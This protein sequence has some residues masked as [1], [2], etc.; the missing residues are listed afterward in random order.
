MTTNEK[1]LSMVSSGV[2]VDLGQ[3]PMTYAT[4]VA[5]ANTDF[6][7]RGLRGNVPAL[8]AC[9]LSG[10]ELGLG[11]MESL[12]KIDVIDGRPATSAELLVAMVYKAGHQIFPVTITGTGATARG[13]RSDGTTYDFTFSEEDAKRANLL[14]KAN[15][16][17]W[18]G[19]MYYWRAA[20][21]LCRILFPDVLTSFR[22]YTP[23]DLGSEEWQ[24]PEP[25]ANP[26]VAEE[27]TD[28]PAYAPGEE[29]FVEEVKP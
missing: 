4:L 22:A 21:Q 17:N 7:P 13:I 26:A 9:I 5:I 2:G 8:L 25:T 12:Q 28:A 29:P 14:G 19:P 27:V 16:K 11:P 18:P 24:P 20:S 15:W 1:A 10:R 3:A 23:D 6:V